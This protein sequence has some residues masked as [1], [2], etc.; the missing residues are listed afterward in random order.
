MM[1]FLSSDENFACQDMAV[2]IHKP[3]AYVCATKPY[4]TVA[5]QGTGQKPQSYS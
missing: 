5:Y 2:S 3:G 4:N 1:T